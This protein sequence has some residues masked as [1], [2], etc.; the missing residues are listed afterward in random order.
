MPNLTQITVTD[1]IPTNGTGTVSTIDALMADGGQAT[2]GFK[3]DAADPSTSTQSI[4]AMSV[5]KQISKSVQ[6]LVALLPTALGSGGGLKIDGSGTAL[7]VTLTGTSVTT[8]VQGYSAKTSFT[9]GT[10][11]VTAGGTIGATGNSTLQFAAIAPGSGC[12]EI[13]G[14][15]LEF[16][17]AA[18]VS[19]ETS[20]RLYLYSAAPGS[21]LSNGTAWSLQSGDRSTFLGYVDLGNVAAI[22]SSVV[23]AEVNNVGKQVKL[24]SANLFAY[25]VSNGAYTPT[26]ETVSVTIVAKTV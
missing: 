12:I 24:N 11:A 14:V 9:V 7:P 15:Q 20:Y 4:S 6:A 1:G 18:I 2:I 5:W 22:G 19:G 17:R 8:L 3:D 26:G 13:R 10:A 25:L 21:A 23:Y 16:D